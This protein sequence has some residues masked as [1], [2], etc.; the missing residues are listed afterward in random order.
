MKR[1]TST[2]AKGFVCKLLYVLTQRKELWNQAKK[3]DF[4]TRMTL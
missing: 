4:V 2:L 3:Y 1:V